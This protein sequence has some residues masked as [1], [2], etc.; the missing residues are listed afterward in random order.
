MTNPVRCARCAARPAIACDE[1]RR[2]LALVDRGTGFG[3]T[4]R[5]PEQ[6]TDCRLCNRGA[7]ELCC[8]CRCESVLE[9][10]AEPDSPYAPLSP[11]DVAKAAEHWADW[12]D[13]GP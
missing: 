4:A 13:L 7:V 3:G 2:A 12:R 6:G 10:R 1:C 8:E 5:H 11:D 9:L